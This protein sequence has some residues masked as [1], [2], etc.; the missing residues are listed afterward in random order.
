MSLQ[1]EGSITFWLDAPEVDWQT[2]SKPYKFG[3]MSS[4]GIEVTAF[5]NPDSTL[6]ILISGPLSQTII[7]HG[8]MPRVHHPDGL[9]V[10]I[11]WR[12]PVVTLYVGPDNVAEFVLSETQR[13]TLPIRISSPGDTPSLDV[14]GDILDNLSHVFNTVSGFLDAKDPKVC[15]T[16][17]TDGLDL[18]KFSVAS[19]TTGSWQALLNGTKSVFDF[20]RQRFGD[21]LSVCSG[22]GVRLAQAHVALIEADARIRH[23]KANQERITTIARAS[24]I[25]REIGNHL[26]SY[27]QDMSEAD[28]EQLL[29]EHFYKP[30]QQLAST[31]V[32]NE[33]EIEF[34]DPSSNRRA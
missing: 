20:V 11:T 12:H 25:A 13:A 10:A 34:R 5:K 24:E 7:F 31:I 32:T 6:A 21:F 26:A 23:E 18:S 9:F 4:H 1:G 3:P 8:P 22:F 15:V 14:I 28:K 16:T 19:S 27:R 29:N 30:M 2:N 33:L 17:I